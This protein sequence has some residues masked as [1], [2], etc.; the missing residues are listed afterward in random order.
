MGRQRREGF[1]LLQGIREGF[2]EKVIVGQAL[3]YE[4]TCWLEKSQKGFHV[5]RKIWARAC[6]H[7]TGWHTQGRMQHS[8]YGDLVSLCLHLSFL[9]IPILVAEFPS[10]SNLWH[11]FFFLFT[12][13]SVPNTLEPYWIYGWMNGSCCPNV[14][15]G[16]W[17][18]EYNSTNASG[19]SSL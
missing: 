3:Q 6:G 18:W 12:P 7:K 15:L 9:S 1:S 2:T 17:K 13:L 8:V 11:C 4:Y 5:K 16:T 14:P 10:P 19:S